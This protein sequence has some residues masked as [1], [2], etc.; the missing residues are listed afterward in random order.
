MNIMQ[1][2]REAN[3]VRRQIWDPAGKLTLTFYIN[4]LGGEAGELCNKLKK[5]ERFQSGLRGGIADIPGIIEELA[6]CVICIDLC[7]IAAGH[8]PIT[9]SRTMWP[10]TR[11]LTPSEMGRRLL[12][13]L[14]Y[15]AEDPKHMDYDDL[16]AVIQSI[17]DYFNI[18]LLEAVQE[19]FN[20]TSMKYDLPVQIGTP[21]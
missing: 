21:I 18:D 1:K 14:G 6:D 12:C 2:L 8:D 16:L 11:E 10:P 19:K 3:L 9:D 13:E 17:A 20:A 7:Q 5:L 4:E 15:L